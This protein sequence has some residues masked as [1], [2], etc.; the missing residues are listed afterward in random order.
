M[1]RVVRILMVALFLVSP[2]LAQE[3]T[4]EMKKEIE[5]L[6]QGQKSIQKDLKDIKTLLKALATRKGRPAQPPFKPSDIAI[7]GSPVMGQADAPVT[8]VEFA[9]FFLEGYSENGC[10]GN[11]CEIEGRFINSNTNYG[12]L[13]GVY[14]ENTF[15]HF[16]RLVN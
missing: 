12:A 9:L 16:V 2:A 15:A 14:D 11:D 1:I 8:I 6:K 10:T 5:A 13:M 4:D 3:T 7:N